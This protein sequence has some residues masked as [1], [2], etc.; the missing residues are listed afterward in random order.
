MLVMDRRGRARQV[1]DLIDLQI[2]REREIVADQLKKLLVKEVLDVASGA[3]KEVI[4]TQDQRTVRKEMLAQ[5]RAEEARAT[6]YQYPL[7]KMH[8]C[9][10]ICHPTGFPARR[11]TLC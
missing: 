5:M 2:K 4:N 3:G 11:L 7:F 10:L 6:R 8:L 9:P 1:V